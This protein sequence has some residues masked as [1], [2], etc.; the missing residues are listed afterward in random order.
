MSRSSRCALRSMI[1]RKRS[2]TC[3]IVA[4]AVEQRFD[5]AFDERKRRAQFVADVGDKFLARAFELLEPRQ[6][7]ENQN[8]PFAFAGGIG[9][10]GGVDLQPA[11]AQ[12]RQL[13]FVIENL[14]F[15]LDALDEFGQFVQAQRL[16][17]GFAAQFGFEAEQIF[18]GAVGEINF[19]VAVEQQQAFEHGIEQ[20]L[21]LRLGVNRRLLLPALG[22]LHLRR[23]LALL[24]RGISSATR[25][26]GRRARQSARMER[27]SHMGII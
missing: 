10:D 9:D 22:F 5:V 16:H 2:A 27:K 23:A 7:V 12:V 21:L 6:I 1:F 20:H 24:A 11:F 26:A 17:D 4:R 13:Q 25:N 15:G 8:R 3:G 14:P 19:P 18:E